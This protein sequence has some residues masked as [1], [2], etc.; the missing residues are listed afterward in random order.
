MSNIRIFTVASE[1][2]GERVITQTEKLP[3]KNF[4]PRNLASPKLIFSG[5]LR[6]HEIQN[7]TDLRHV[8]H[9]ASASAFCSLT[10]YS[11]ILTSF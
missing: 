4:P 1:P 10:R 9:G 2:R 5:N 8:P 6:T 7:H 11:D 3:S